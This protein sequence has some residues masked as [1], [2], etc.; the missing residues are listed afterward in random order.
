MNVQSGAKNLGEPRV[1]P[2]ADGLAAIL[3]HGKPDAATA[4]A[5]GLRV[6]SVAAG[7]GNTAGADWTFRGSLSNGSG[8]AGKIIF[9]SSLS[10]AGSGTQNTASAALTIS[11]PSAT[12]IAF[13]GYGAGALSTDASGNITATSDERVKDIIGTFD[14]GLRELMALQPIRYHWKP[15]S[16]ME[17]GGEYAGFGASNVFGAIPLATGMTPDGM[18]TLQDRA[19]LAA[20]VNAIKEIGRRVGLA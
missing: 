11:N 20:C 18:R 16:G 7:N 3:Q 8:A 15:E 13:N 10:A 14:A 9:Q 6:Q 2:L 19:L 5:Q 1:Q 12:G 4:T 17:T